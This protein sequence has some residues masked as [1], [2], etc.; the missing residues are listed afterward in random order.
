MPPTDI[1]AC[2]PM[3]KQCRPPGAHNSS[4]APVRTITQDS[5]STTLAI[6]SRRARICRIS[7][8]SEAP[9]QCAIS[10]A[11]GVTTPTIPVGQACEGRARMASASMMRGILDSTSFSMISHTAS[12]EASSRPSPGPMRTAWQPR[13]VSTRSRIGP[14]E[15]L[16]K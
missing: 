8:G 4:S 6:P 5:S 9:S 10:V 13:P 15:R 12:I 11:C 1:R 16:V 2:P 7:V 14:T 3:A